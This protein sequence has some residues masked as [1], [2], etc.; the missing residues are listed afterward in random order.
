MEAA[1]QPQDP[2]RDKISKSSSSESKNLSNRS[3][4]EES[5]KNK[6][7]SD[8]SQGCSAMWAEEVL[9]ASSGGPKFSPKASG[10]WGHRTATLLPTTGQRTVGWVGLMGL[11][12]VF[13]RVSAL[14]SSQGLWSCS[15]CPL[16]S[17]A[18]WAIREPRTNEAPSSHSTRQMSQG[19]QKTRHRFCYS[20]FRV[21]GGGS[22]NCSAVRPKLP[23]WV[24]P[25]FM[26]IL[27]L[28]SQ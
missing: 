10:S 20:E 5:R 11:W 28:K 25:K 16:G 12:P 2:Q 21:R 17:W 4:S 18:G 15:L 23:P 9:E 8:P 13:Y 22:L 27:L 24:T 7:S 3:T 26:Q 14:S 1:L 19:R 6:A